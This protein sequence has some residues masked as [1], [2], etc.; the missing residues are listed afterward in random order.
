MKI[1]IIPK[2]LNSISAIRQAYDTKDTE[3]SGTIPL[4][5]DAK[6]GNLIGTKYVLDDIVPGTVSIT[7]WKDKVVFHTH[8]LKYGA[9]Y[10]YPSARDIYSI[11]LRSIVGNVLVSLIFTPHFIYAIYPSEALFDYFLSMEKKDPSGTRT[12]LF[13]KIRTNFMEFIENLSDKLSDLDI[14][15]KEKCSEGLLKEISEDE[16]NDVVDEVT[17]EKLLNIV[18]QLGFEIRRIDLE[19]ALVTLSE[20]R[21]QEITA[22]F[23]NLEIEVP[24][25][26]LKLALRLMNWQHPGL[27]E[28][29][30]QHGI[31]PLITPL[32]EEESKEIELYVGKRREPFMDF[33]AALEREIKSLALSES[34]EDLACPG[35]VSK[36]KKRFRPVKPPPPPPRSKVIW[37]KSELD[38]MLNHLEHLKKSGAPEKE[39]NSTMELIETIKKGLKEQGDL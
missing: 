27:A 18:K 2:V 38:N 22:T 30:R 12:D 16:L 15:I 39:I 36:Y 34:K 10:D 11:W 13:G 33:H 29:M 31:G 24:D 20:G 35:G 23:S 21:Q 7:S 3:I 26:E 9:H 37:K 25:I 19:P 28:Y 17:G 5:L 32:S 4:E 1:I 14:L 6:T 8:P